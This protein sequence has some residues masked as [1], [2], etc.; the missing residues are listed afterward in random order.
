LT[1]RGPRA[2]LGALAEISGVGNFGSAAKVRKYTKSYLEK[3]L[4]ELR[5]SLEVNM[6]DFGISS[7]DTPVNTFPHIILSCRG[8]LV[9]DDGTFGVVIESVDAMVIVVEKCRWNFEANFAIRIRSK[10]MG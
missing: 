10:S 3:I 4:L 1:I 9:T 5:G 8:L 2:L 6:F 7:S